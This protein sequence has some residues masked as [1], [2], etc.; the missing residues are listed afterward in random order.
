MIQNDTLIQ[1]KQLADAFNTFFV[2]VVHRTRDLLAISYVT[3]KYE[4]SIF[5]NGTDEREIVNPFTTEKN[6]TSCD[7]GGFQVKSIKFVIEL[8]S[9]PLPHMFNLSFY[10]SKKHKFWNLT[11]NKYKHSSYL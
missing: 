6:C 2:N 4:N 8:L 10:L 5:W 11:L 1:G 9:Q 7:V 3:N